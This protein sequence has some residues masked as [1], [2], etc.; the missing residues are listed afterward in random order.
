MNFRIFHCQRLGTL[1]NLAEADRQQVFLGGL[2]TNGEDGKFSYMWQ[3]DIMQV[4]SIYRFLN[5][6]IRKIRFFWK[7]FTQI[8][9][10]VKPIDISIDFHRRSYFTLPL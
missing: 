9:K 10:I 7:F 2:Q 1:I 8:L 4:R 5:N 3:D 6:Q